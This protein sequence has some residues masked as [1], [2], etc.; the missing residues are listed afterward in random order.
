MD[1]QVSVLFH[2]LADLA[3]PE[4]EKVFARRNVSPEL[5]A[6]VESLLACDASEDHVV[7]GCIG[8]AAEAAVRASADG[9]GASCGPYRLIRL[10]GSG[11]MGTVYL[12]ERADGEIQQQVAI[13]MLRIGA[14]QASWQERFL[15]ERQ[16]LAYLNHPSVARLLDAG[17]AEQ[18][19]P[20]LVME[21]VDGLPID[22][23]AQGK[24]LRE[25]L[26]LFLK[27]C[28]GV[29]HAHRHLI[30]HRDLKP[31]NILVDRS[32]QPKLLDFG[33]AKLL[34]EAGHQTKT[35]ELL[36]T[37]SYA[38]P[39]QVRGGVQ[40]TATDV[41]SLGAVLYKILTG[42]SPHESEDG[43]LQAIEIVAGTR[44]IPPPSRVNPGLARDLDF[45]LLKALRREPEQRY[46]SVEAFAS[47]IRAFLES[48]PVHA[49]TVDAWY[50]TRKF[51][52]RHWAQVTASAAVVAS[53]S[54]GL[55]VANR[56][57]LMAEQRFALL[58]QLS[59]KVFEL[60]RRIKFLPGSMP[61]R[62]DL[63]AASLEYLQGLQF[64]ARK[65]LDL[66]QEVAE[67]YLRIGRIQGVPTEMNFGDAAQA[68][69][70]LKKSADLTDLVLAA[71]PQ[72]HAALL[73]SA[74]IAHDRMILAQEAH[75]RM[76]ALAYA[77]KASEGFDRFLRRGDAAQAEINLIAQRYNNIG[78]AYSNMRLYPEAIE[79]ARLGSKL[80]RSIPSA[81]FLV[82]SSLS[83][84]ANALR[85]Q[86]DLDGA[87]RAI[88]QAREFEER[89]VYP[90]ATVGALN[91]YSLLLRE[92][93][94]LAEDGGIN[95]DR[96]EDAIIPL[97]EALDLNEQMAERDPND[98]NSR[99]R[100]G[101]SA[102]ELGN[103]LRRRDPGQ[104]LA[105]YDLGIRRL[106]EIRNN[107]KARRDLAELLA[108]SSYALRSLNRMRE[109]AERIDE[110]STILTSAKDYSAAQVQLGESLFL[111]LKA[112]IDDEA[113]RGDPRRAAAQ[114]EELLQK[115][116][117]AKPEP[118][119]DLRD[120]TRLSRFY[121]TLATCYDR[122]GEKAK[123]ESIDQQRLDLWQS[124][125]RKLPNN[126]F[127][128]RQ[129]RYKPLSR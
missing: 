2:E 105:V 78:L 18:G 6:E 86:G 7:T 54:A 40:T 83:V 57:R 74:D 64:D 121:E 72:D 22:S 24:S 111:V 85:L 98:Y 96:P 102:R 107:L 73:R 27:I 110:S 75:R 79:S 1:E 38:S 3:P 46:A 128:L 19:R 69:V 52:R 125:D 59:N 53:L 35:A 129:I 122:I 65:D 49:R 58:R 66:T 12:A 106:R 36:L 39:E 32:G 20:Y 70:S 99:S 118:L 95:L 97:R 60:D 80:A 43:E 101:T 84:M 45:V 14:D 76:D 37:P 62:R 5:R 109:A 124:W 88:R 55:Y 89:A 8:L 56:G 21:Y 93:M 9:V 112:R 77:R 81:E 51:L 47:D 63:V 41:Y 113:A 13:K 71:R 119:T 34:D 44:E 28:D 92:G 61:A 94:I 114:Y 42:R 120:A 117:A 11:G 91:R 115:I 15:R 67:G 87:L 127:V 10:L 17:R 100:V 23:S 25:Q 30:I 26:M 103:I 48:R 116:M 90:N 123:A 82:S 33:I 68:D 29:A 104:A 4:R 50:R 31:S 126:A 108:G 16:L